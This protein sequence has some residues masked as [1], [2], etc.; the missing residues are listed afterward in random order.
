MP[1]KIEYLEAERGV[2]TTCSGLITAEEFEQC[3]KEKFFRNGVAL[4]KEEIL[5]YRYS[6]SDLSAVTDSDIPQRA[7]VE[8]AK[9]TKELLAIHPKGIFAVVAPQDIEFGL[10]RMWQAYT[11]NQDDR[12]HIFKSRKAAD[13]WIKQ[14]LK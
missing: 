12:V 10:G 5:Y 14:S 2:V 13:R 1:Y 4:T 3:S 11:E 7:L 8:N 6:L 9:M